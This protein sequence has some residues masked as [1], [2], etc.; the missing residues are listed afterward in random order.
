MASGENHLSNLPDS[1]LEIFLNAMAGLLEDAVD[2][3]SRGQ[4]EAAGEL[5]REAT[6]LATAAGILA[7][8]TL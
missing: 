1:L 5:A 8:R 6:T 3:I 4:L 7:R 2:E